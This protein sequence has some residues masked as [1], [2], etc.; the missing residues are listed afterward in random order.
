MTSRKR[1][2]RIEDR[3]LTGN[4]KPAR[5]Y[6]A[7]A[8]RPNVWLSER[9][10]MDIAGVSSAL[11]SWISS[12][13]NSSALPAD[14]RISECRSDRGKGRRS[15]RLERAAPSAEN[16][17]ARVERRA[18]LDAGRPVEAARIGR[19]RLAAAVAE[20]GELFPCR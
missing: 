9:E 2:G 19:A 3:S 10:I 11:S 18:A 14:E 4:G 5:V 15:W 1:P 6:R 13:R 16:E 12:V 8:A 20:P 7:F 17:A